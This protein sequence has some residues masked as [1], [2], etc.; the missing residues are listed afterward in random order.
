[1]TV[2][3]FTVAHHEHAGTLTE[4]SCKDLFPVG[5]TSTDKVAKTTGTEIVVAVFCF[6]FIPQASRHYFEAL[7]GGCSRAVLPRGWNGT[8]LPLVTLLTG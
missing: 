4:T 1:M 3:I 8:T 7:D 5:L 6:C 2:P